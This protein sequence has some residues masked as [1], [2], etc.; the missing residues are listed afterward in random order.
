V[1]YLERMALPS[2]LDGLP[3]ILSAV[4]ADLHGQLR[5]ATDP[6]SGGATA[7][8]MAASLGGLVAAG[9]AAGLTRLRLLVVKSANEATITAV[10]PDEF[11]C[12]ALSPSKGSARAEKALQEWA[13]ADDGRGGRAAT[14]A[15]APASVPTPSAKP[16]SSPTRTPIPAAA[17]TPT[18]T[19]PR[20]PSHDAWAEF[21]R[22]LVRGLLTDAAAQR[23]DLAAASGDGRPGAEPLPARELDQ[24]IQ[25]LVQGIGSVLAGDGLG[26]ARTLEPLL[27]GAQPNLSCRWLALFWSARA[28][29]RSGD[30]TAARGHVKQALVVAKSLDLEALAASHWIAAEVLAHDG[31]AAR[32]LAFLAHARNGFQRLDD[33]WGVGQAWL[34]E[35]RV[36]AATGREDGAAEAARQAWASDPSWE[37]PPVFLARRALAG[38]DLDGAQDMLRSAEGPA[39]DRVR[40]LVEAMR[41]QVVGAA[42]ASE[43]LRVSDAP[44]SAGSIRALERIAGVAPRFLQA[45]EALAWMLLKTGRYAEASTLF[46]GLLAR[47]LAA[48]DRASVMLGLGCIAHAQQTGKSA[49]ARLQATVAAAGTPPAPEP[50]TAGET[51]PPLPLP[52]RSSQFV[53]TSAVFSGQLGVFA[54]PDVVEFVRSARR[55]GLLVCSAPRGIATVHFRDGRI[56]GATSPS[57]PS[58]RELLLRARKISTVA[59]GA[60]AGGRPADEP[61][62]VLAELLVAEG[63]IDAAAAEDALRRQAVAT[64]TEVLG[65]KAGE[66]AF[67]REGE[68]EPGSAAVEVDA[69]EVLLDVLRRM[70]EA[71]R[72][73]SGA[74]AQR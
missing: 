4:S 29:L 50:M 69:Q 12:V 67:S 20:N 68:D 15:P 57:T 9:D 66:F 22:T 11:L 44:P 49:D 63:A 74:A 2:L 46:R 31:D 60:L 71:K 59:L 14:P 39:T 24:T 65:W 13:A 54:L 70:D 42:E 8:S 16:T 19:A 18:V 52:G 58:L 72:D 48:G 45:R 64:L 25:L 38:G 28:A 73:L 55:T 41:E 61:D 21:R 36:L 43:F 17:P 35:A 30:S 33:R 40:A 10:R 34:A 37:E 62:H 26:G 27:G 6:T 32:A 56:T 23:R 47:P 5:G 53:T 7:T 51:P 1:Q 3:E